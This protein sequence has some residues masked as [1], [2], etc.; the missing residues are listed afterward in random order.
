MP[1]SVPRPLLMLPAILLVL[2]L[3]G[4]GLFL[5]DT[6]PAPSRPTVQG[7]TLPQ[8]AE[9][10][11][12]LRSVVPVWVEAVGAVRPRGEIAVS[13]QVQAEVRRVLVRAGQ[14]VRRGEPL[15]ELDDRELQARLAQGRHELEAMGSAQ[16]RARRAQERT[17]AEFDLAQAEFERIQALHNQGA[18]ATRELD[19]ARAGFLAARAESGRA[20]QGIQELIAQQARL[21]QRIEELTVGLG[22]TSIAASEDGIIARRFVEPGDVVQPGQ[23]LFLLHSPDVRLEI[24]VPERFHAMMTVGAEFTARVDALGREFP[25]VVDEVVPLAAADS[26]T[27]TIKLAPAPVPSAIATDIPWTAELRPGMFVRLHIPVSAEPMVLVDSRAVLR[28]GQLE[29]A[30]VIRDDSTYTLR[31]LRLGRVQNDQVEVLSGLEGGERLW[32]QPVPGP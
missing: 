26:R 28:V 2:V 11:I 32:L 8:D 22:H 27:F 3:L 1:H 5:K 15:L 12:A 4:T 6:P 19:Q 13:A 18:A 24:Q 16:K 21:E 20:E 25:V 23:T 10:T 30:A 7:E 9:T 29:L 31:H 17:R 14:Q